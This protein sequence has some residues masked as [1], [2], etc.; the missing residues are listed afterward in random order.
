MPPPPLACC[1]CITN[2]Y[3]ARRCCVRCARRWLSEMDEGATYMEGLTSFTGID[4]SQVR[5]RCWWQ[6]PQLQRVLLPLHP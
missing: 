1:C 6:A 3:H 4:F 2:A 5:V